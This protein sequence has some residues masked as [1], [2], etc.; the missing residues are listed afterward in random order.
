MVRK[1]YNA[2][3]SKLKE[4]D[5]VSKNVIHKDVEIINGQYGEWIHSKKGSSF[6]AYGGA[7]YLD[8][9]SAD[10]DTAQKEM[11]LHFNLSTEQKVTINLP[12]ADLTESKIQGL[13]EYGVQVNKNTAVA[14]IKTIEN[15]EP[16]ARLCM[17]YKKLGFATFEGSKIFKGYKAIGTKA[18]YAGKLRVTPK[19][20]YENWRAMV[21]NEVIG[22]IPL[23]FTLAVAVSGLLVDFLKGRM[24]LENV[25][26]HYIGQSSTGK[27]T[28]ALLAVSCGSAPDFM[29]ENF[30]FSFQDTHNSL[31]QLLPSSYPALIDE[32][33]LIGNKKDMTQSMYSLS[34]GVEKRRLSKNL[35]ARDVSRFRTAIFLTS[36]KSI[37]SQ[38][39]ENS[40][41]LVR[42]I[43]I[44]NVVYTKSAHSADRIKNT[45]KDNYGFIVPKVAEWL[46]DKGE[47]DVAVMVVKETEYLIQQA[48]NNNEY[49]NLTERSAKQS[50]LI[51]VAVDI[52]KE[53][54]QLCFNK[55]K[56]V[57]FLHEHSLVKDTETVSMGMRAMDFLLQVIS[58]DSIQFLKDNEESEIRECKGRLKR[59]PSKLLKTGETS[60]MRVLITKSE[61]VKILNQGG[62]SEEKIILKEWKVL[63]YLQA[64][65]DRYISDVSIVKGIPS[66]GYIINLP[67]KESPSEE[68]KVQPNQKKK[69]CEEDLSF[70]E[71]E[72]DF[73]DNE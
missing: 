35:E 63:G 50:A 33:S 20:T 31:M 60:T 7:V 69:E 9:V 36:E 55:P 3:I 18:D 10:I 62:F 29:G 21:Q 13:A 27:T 38:C 40:G 5:Q 34:S 24:S 32:G 44:D 25:V 61:F 2:E 47:D 72:I 8:E 17:K 28:A 16:S 12:R 37:L 45:I 14:L 30:V 56:I 4:C 39:N 51:L 57:E 11:K 71:E 23:E 68:K 67:T 64:E 54:L 43:E 53:V 58:K 49:N 52:L 48:K 73:E 6:Y 1:M 19:G 59:V 22:Q 66:K 65:K 41:L 26:C 15:Q 42:N 46:L 70:L